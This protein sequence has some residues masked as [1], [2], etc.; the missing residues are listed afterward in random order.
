MSESRMMA[1][2]MANLK[3]GLLSRETAPWLHGAMPRATA[4]GYLKRHGMEEGLFLVR[5][6]DSATETFALSMVVQGNFVHHL[7]EKV[8]GFFQVNQ[9]QLGMCTSLVELINFLRLPRD[10]WPLPLKKPLTIN[11]VQDA[12]GRDEGY[13]K[14]WEAQTDDLYMMTP[15]AAP[16]V[17]EG[18][19]P[20][21]SPKASPNPSRPSPNTGG[22]PRRQISL[23]LQPTE[24]Q[25]RSPLDAKAYN[26]NEAIALRARQGSTNKRNAAQKLDPIITGRAP[27]QLPEELYREP[28]FDDAPPPVIGAPPVV[29][30]PPPGPPPGLSSPSPG[31]G[32]PP[33]LPPNHPSE[34]PTPEG[35]VKKKEKSRRGSFANFFRKSSKKK[36]TETDVQ[37]GFV[38]YDVSLLGSAAVS[39]PCGDDVIEDGLEKVKFVSGSDSHPPEQVQVKISVQGF[40]IQ[41]R[42]KSHTIIH[43]YP[44]EHI[45]YARIDSQDVSL[46]VL[47]ATRTASRTR[48]RPTHTCIVIRADK[49]DST[50]VLS[51]F[52]EA[53][54]AANCRLRDE[55]PASFLCNEALPETTADVFDPPLPTRQNSSAQRQWSKKL[56]HQ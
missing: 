35:S 49:C 41:S 38:T 51:T 1:Q 36:V 11:A 44:V 17:P 15:N 46:V 33:P 34:K 28:E 5:A 9:H 22:G 54:V 14:L 6:K 26:Q 39:G 52:R 37:S 24:E 8:E 25:I 53:I 47:I 43:Q 40:S 27:Q 50:T 18:I 45:S 48:P 20:N 19:N 13:E 21:P 23:R 31:D 29:G 55:S 42:D 32:A 4:E 7:L 2:K 3:A 56:E 30:A 12:N 10:G 16:R